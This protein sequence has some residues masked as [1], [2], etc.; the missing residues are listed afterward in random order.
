LFAIIGLFHSIFGRARL[1][2]PVYSFC[3][4]EGFNAV[5]FHAIIPV[6]ERYFESKFHPPAKPDLRLGAMWK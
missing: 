6:K 2:S 5:I 4:R 3:A 1:C